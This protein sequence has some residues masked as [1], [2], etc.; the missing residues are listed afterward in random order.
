MPIMIYNSQTR[1]KEEFTPLTP[2]K[3]NMYV[4][5]VTV[6]DDA[7]VGH[8]RVYVAFDA[9]VRH[10]QARGLE[11]NYVRNFTDIEDKIIK[12]AD[13]LGIG[14]GELTRRYMDSFTGDMQSLGVLP[15]SHEPKATEVV[16]QIIEAVEEL[17]EKGNAYEVDGDVY[18]SVD[19][20]PHYGALSGRNLDDLRA[21]AR[22]G[23]DERK[24]NPLDFALWKSSKPGEPTWESP[25]GPGRPGWH[26]ECTV[27]SR[28]FI[29]DT[30]DIHGGGED[31]V[32]PH[33]ENEM[34]QS[35]A[36][37]GKTF[38]HYWIHNGFVRV[39]QEKMSKSLG[40]F[41]TIKDIL[42]KVK[43]E[44]LRFFLLSKHYRSPLDFSA[45]PP[46]TRRPRPWSGCTTPCWPRTE[47]VDGQMVHQTMGKPEERD[48]L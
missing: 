13:E 9:M 41:F 39:N 44:V 48:G 36:L 23:V 20:F 28:M 14:T 19:S 30:L 6:Y 15:V 40:N 22:V 18:F 29:G 47:N 24:R 45:T 46:W 37:T 1:K 25:W 31:L 10:F 33:H 17:I 38:A 16:P 27:M 3:V 35:M 12:R 43:P 11:V 42:K 5:G 8:A 21:G 4:C 2:G 26:I 34:A 7:H 32:F